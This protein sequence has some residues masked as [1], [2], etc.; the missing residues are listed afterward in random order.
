M[1]HFQFE[2]SPP[3]YLNKEA[4]YEIV[5]PHDDVATFNVLDLETWPSGDDIQLNE[6]QFE[7]YKTALTHEFAV[8]QGPPG[9]GK[10]YLG[11]KIAETLLN[12]ISTS[13][14]LLLLVCYTNHALDQFLQALIK[15]TDSIVR[16]GGRS[17]NEA[18]EKFNLNE[19]RKKTKLSQS[20]Y[21]LFAEQRDDLKSSIFQLQKAQKDLDSIN[22]DIISFTCM[23]HYVPDCQVLIHSYNAVIKNNQD[24][25]YYWLFEN[26][27]YDFNEPILFEDNQ[28]EEQLYKENADDN[29][30]TF[31]LDDLEIDQTHSYNSNEID[32]VFSVRKVEH[33]LSYMINEYHSKTNLEQK[34]KLYRTIVIQ[35]TKIRLFK[36]SSYMFNLL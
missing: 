21:R 27:P 5:L 22:N 32:T 10:T 16:I 34:E 24:P 1:F 2:P 35:R 12:N 28:I 19:I 6:S 9:T 18:L 30:N 8:I 17:R 11:I 13:G 29:R 15:V 26:L 4:K 25:L 36:V 7:A 23:R 31:I 3:K 33:T 14:C 20:E